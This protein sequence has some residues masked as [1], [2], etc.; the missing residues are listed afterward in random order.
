MRIRSF[1]AAL[2]LITCASA[3]HAANSAPRITAPPAVSSATLV[4]DDTTPYVVTMTVSDANGYNDI[5]CVR[6]LFGFS[7]S[8]GDQSK[9]RGYMAWGLTDATITRFG[10]TWI[11]GDASGGARWA[12]RTDQWGGTTYVTPLSCST[13]TSGKATGGTGYRTVSWTFTVKP[14]WAWNPLTNMA[15]GWVDDASGAIVGWQPSGAEFDVVA[16]ACASHPATP[17]AP[18][19]SDPTPSTVKIAIDPADSDTDLF[20]IRI[21]PTLDNRAWVQGN[22]SLG[23]SP[24]YQTKAAWGTKTITGLASSTAYTLTVRA[25]RNEPGSCPSEYGQAA[26]IS[27]SLLSH[28]IDAGAAGKSTYRGVIGNATRLDFY[29]GKLRMIDKLW[30]VLED[31]CARGVAGG[32][33]ADTY[34]WKDMSGQGVGHTGVPSSVVP[35]TLDWMRLAR[36]HKA[37]PLITANCRGI[38]PLDSSGYSRFYYTDTDISTVAR[39]AADWVRYINYILPTYRQGDTL[40]PADQAILD[41]INW[42][43]RPKLLEPGEAPTPKVTY[44]EIGNEPEVPLP[45]STPGATIMAPSPAEY[46]QRYKQ[47]TSA[48]RAVDASIKTGP[49]ITTANNGNA[50]LE[51]LLDDSAAAVDFVSYHPY[52]PLYAYAN[53]YG[54]TAAAAESALRYIKS[55]QDGYYNGIVTCINSS[56]R[57][58]SNMKLLISEQNPSDWH[59]EC[60]TQ[61]ARMSHALGLAESILT[62][63]EQGIYSANYWSGPA[64]CSDGTETPG[65]KVFKKF[66]QTL[67]EGDLLVDS[68]SDGVNIRAYTLW[69]SHTQDLNLWVLNFSNTQDMPLRFGL[70]NCGTA[71]RVT[72]SLLAKLTGPTSLLDINSTPYTTP[73]NIEWTDTDLTGA[74]DPSGFTMT[75]PRAT[76]TVLTFH[77]NIRALPDSVPIALSGMVVTAAYP[78]EGYFYIESDDRTYGIRVAGSLSGLTVGD[79]VK[80]VGNTS[81]RKISNLPVERQV[82][83]TSITKL[84]SG[85]ALKPV[86]MNCRTIGGGPIGTA[87]GVKGASGVNNIGLLVTIAGR[88][89]Y[90]VGS[91]IIIDDGTNVFDAQGRGTVVVKCPGTSTYA[92]GDIVRVT[93][94]TEASLPAGWTENRRYMRARTWGDIAKVT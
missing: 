24:V 2:A 33:D 84:S 21:S 22:G 65:Y 34:N 86:G 77:R 47:I 39:L 72:K 61:A 16:A 32:L 14:A 13:S 66:Q 3:M 46:L 43:D 74:I 71:T 93:G 64:W 75:F 40:L 89:T 7:T 73:P 59:W 57:G 27:T 62:F 25:V 80:V 26:V 42:G 79:R 44:W 38:G 63:M 91:T 51:T 1:L 78:S 83:A 41:S 18:V 68:F 85:S 76:I 87:P 56:G 35:T 53:S 67:S 6:V 4:A 45:W 23:V 8:G 69:N 11:Y 19:V 28:T 92:I 12:Y 88:V 90:S 29:P 10:G 17:R 49:C 94:V 50:W 52:G 20:A 48:M 37:R 5:N 60:S 54:D 70:T 9:G 36:D 55:Q 58:L 82:Y 31:T 15:D 81:T 30:A